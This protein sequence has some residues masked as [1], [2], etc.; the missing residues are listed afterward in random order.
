M[1]WTLLPIAIGFSL[2]GCLAIFFSL[3]RELFLRVFIPFDELRDAIPELND[4]QKFRRGVG[5][6]GILQLIVGLGFGLRHLWCGCLSNC[7]RLSVTRAR[8]HGFCA[9]IS[10]LLRLLF[11]PRGGGKLDYQSNRFL[12]SVAVS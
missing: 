8:Q 2:L 12:K 6:T 3:N 9:R 1:H 4:E 7:R 10:A 11:K 5:W